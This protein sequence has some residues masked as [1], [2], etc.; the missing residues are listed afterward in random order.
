M[1]PVMFCLILKFVSS[2]GS[3]D[4]ITPSFFSHAIIT[5]NMQDRSLRKKKKN[6]KKKKKI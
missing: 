5:Q 4:I 6:K 2:S 3:G 1:P